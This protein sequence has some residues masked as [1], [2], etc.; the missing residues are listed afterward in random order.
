MALQHGGAPDV[1]CVPHQILAA[2]D[3]RPQVQLRHSV[4]PRGMVRTHGSWSRLSPTPST[5]IL[6]PRFLS[7]RE[8]ERE[9][10]VSVYE[11][12]PG[13]RL[14]PR[15]LSGNAEPSYD[16]A[17]ALYISPYRAEPRQVGRD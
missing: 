12:A 8:R 1:Q 3:L 2:H 5:R 16:M 7:E 15:V 4:R 17:R 11:E 13:F 9:R 10:R 6:N 14:G